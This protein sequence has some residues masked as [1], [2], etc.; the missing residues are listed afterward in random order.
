MTHSSKKRKRR[1]LPLRPIAT[2]TPHN[3]N[4]ESKI[5]TDLTITNSSA[6][7]VSSTSDS[8]VFNPPK[9]L[10]MEDS[11]TRSTESVEMPTEDASAGEWG[12]YLSQQ[13]V[14]LNKSLT[15]KYDELKSKL[16][17]NAAKENEQG[18]LLNLVTQSINKLI[19]ENKLV[20]DE[21]EL[22]KE[23]LIK[24]EYHTR[25]N[26]L[27][28]DGFEEVRGESDI[29]CYNSVLGVLCELFVDDRKEEIEQGT[30]LTREQK[31]R[32]ITINRIHC[33]GR[34]IPGRKRA[35]IANFQWYGDVNMILN[36]RKYLPNG[37]YVN[38]DF[39][40]EIVNRR[41]LLRPILKMG[42]Q[43]PH[44][45]GKIKLSYD[46]LIVNG[47]SYT[48][49]QLKDLPNDLDPAKSCEK[50]NNDVVAFFGQHSPLSNFYPC[51]FKSNNETFVSS[52]QYIQ[53]EKA[54]FFNDDESRS[55]IMRL[56]DPREIKWAGD[57]VKGFVA[58]QW[59]RDKARDVARLG[60]LLKFQQNEKLKDYLVKTEGKQIVEGSRD[61][62]WGCGLSLNDPGILDQ[63]KWTN[64]DGGLMHLVLTEVRDAIK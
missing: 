55:K 31:A 25:R 21:N 64:A 17:A 9:K 5:E 36:N 19:R 20:K 13:I 10:N 28:F 24:L 59:E 30:G 2:S 37:I 45:K 15:D 1:E 57:H 27:L 60:C 34:Y 54:G 53:A 61:K 48:V 41:K 39:P 3:K 50:E 22:L 14:N 52:E 58:Q 44:Y 12:K 40:H 29:D 62:L 7:S 46:K 32:K 23:R 47:R 43:L 51:T 16:E 49:S 33:L 6:S 38:E 4:T 8:S 26:N 11:S 35:I 56:T 42:L 63:S 18:K